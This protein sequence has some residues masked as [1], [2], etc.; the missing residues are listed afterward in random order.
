[1]NPK[2]KSAL[3]ASVMV[4]VLAL[5]AVSC[6]PL[7]PEQQALQD[8]A[9]GIS[10][11]LEAAKVAYDKLAVEFAPLAEAWKAGKLTD[12]AAIQRFMALATEVPAAA[13]VVN[14]LVAEG[15]EVLAK[16]R[17]LKTPW[18]FW[19]VPVG[20]V[21]ATVGSF[22]FPVLKPLAAALASAQGQNRAMVNGI[23]AYDRAPETD[24]RE[25]KQ[26]VAESAN[27]LGVL[28]ALDATVQAL[29]KPK[30]AA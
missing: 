16:A 17:E 6:L 5:S 23:E 4:I 12:P 27:R 11:Q 1:M 22:W 30:L 15:K 24:P 26:F 29:T 19:L 2:P 20:S 21:L 13:N 7:T 10:K 9:V 18:Y 28:P 3:A 8:R 14:G 25:V